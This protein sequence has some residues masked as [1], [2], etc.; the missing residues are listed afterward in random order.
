MSKPRCIVSKH[1]VRALGHDVL[2]SALINDVVTPPMVTSWIDIISLTFFIQ[3]RPRNSNSKVPSEWFMSWFN[4]QSN[5]CFR[6]LSIWWADR[7]RHLWNAIGRSGS[8]DRIWA[9]RER[10][11]SGI[12]P[13]QTFSSKVSPA[14]SYVNLIAKSIPCILSFWSTFYIKNLRSYGNF[15]IWPTFLPGD[16]VSWPTSLPLLL[17]RTMC[18]KF[19]N[20]TSKRSW[21]MLDKTDR[22]TDRQTDR[23]TDKRTNEHTCQKFWQVITLSW[24]QKQFVTR[25]HTLFSI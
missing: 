1:C 2:V 5:V 9:D 17:A 13:R 12:G 22:L 19:G 4:M 18:T 20:D 21:V 16:L 3:S 7:D 8:Q 14:V 15:N 11:V 23:Q 6:I 25:F 10:I 24:A